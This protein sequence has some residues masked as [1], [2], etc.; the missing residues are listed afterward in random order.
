M[1]E[2]SRPPAGCSRGRAGTGTRCL[3]T[4]PAY[5]VS[6]SRPFGRLAAGLRAR[7][8]AAGDRV[9]LWLPNWPEWVF[10]RHALGILGAVAVPINT[11][12]KADELAYCL[13]QGEC[14]ALLSADR[15]LGLDF[16]ATVEGIRAGLPALE[17]VAYPDRSRDARRPPLT[18]AVARAI[19][20]DGGYMIYNSG[21][22]SFSKGVQ[23]T[24]RTLSR[25]HRAAGGDLRRRGML[26]GCRLS[27][28]HLKLSFAALSAGACLVLQDH[29][30]PPATLALLER[31]R[32]TYLPCVDTMLLAMAETGRVDAHDISPLTRIMA[33]PL[34]PAAITVA[35][36]RFKAAQVW[37]GYGSRASA[38]AASPARGRRTRRYSDTVALGIAWWIRDRRDTA[39][40]ARRGIQVRRARDAGYTRCQSRPRALHA[41]WM[42]TAISA[43]RVAA[44]Y[45]SVAGARRCSRPEISWPR[46]RSRRCGRDPRWRSL[47]GA[48][49]D[50]KL[51]EV[52]WLVQLKPAPRAAEELLD[53]RGALAA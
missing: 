46:W 37:T 9:G 4:A 28:R 29:F 16:R 39:G 10:A 53:R 1:D 47:R 40:G 13:R 5:S 8:I 19:A 38:S 35:F 27:S 41:R 30:D 44:S 48:A 43:A 33:A 23:L 34:N 26:I 20:D 14:R 31:E 3:V 18:V 51:G 25:T 6:T 7:G 50:G 36:E 42:R 15:F 2:L 45:A 12:Y 22:P 49:P 24:H 21:T 52:G 32:I 11:R 17:W